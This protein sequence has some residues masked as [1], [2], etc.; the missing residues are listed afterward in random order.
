M[1]LSRKIKANVDVVEILA[2]EKGQIYAKMQL[3]FVGMFVQSTFGCRCR[4]R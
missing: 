3:N 1:F 2:K 4:H